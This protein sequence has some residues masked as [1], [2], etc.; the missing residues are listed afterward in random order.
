MGS[1][2]VVVA[3]L[4]DPFDGI[5]HRHI[6]TLSPNATV[7]RFAKRISAGSGFID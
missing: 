4:L 6:Q 5:G 3:S 7:E 2:I 1:V